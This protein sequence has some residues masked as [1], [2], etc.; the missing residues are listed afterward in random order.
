MDVDEF[1]PGQR[2]LQGEEVEH[3]HALALYT[4]PCTFAQL[5]QRFARR[6]EG[7]HV[8]LLVTPR[9][10]LSGEADRRERAHLEMRHDRHRL[11]LLRHDHR[12]RTLHLVEVLAED[13]AEIGAWHHNQCIEP[14]A[15][16]DILQR[17]E[18]VV[19]LSRRKAFQ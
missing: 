12:Q 15:R 6:H 7:A 16:E 13:A 3:P 14:G 17:C 8:A 5:R 2:L 11:T 10:H 1:G 4:H 9:K 19:A 18:H